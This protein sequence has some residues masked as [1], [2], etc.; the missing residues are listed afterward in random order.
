MRRRVVVVAIAL[1]LFVPCLIVSAQ[2]PCPTSITSLDDCPD[3]GCGRGGDGELNRKKNRT[4]SPDDVE[5][6]TLGQI[7]AMS[8][9][10]TWQTGQD[11][12]SIANG[13]DKAVVVR[14]YLIDARQ[15][16]PETTNCRLTGA[17]NNDWHLDLVSFRSGPRS[18]RASAVSAEVT[19]RLRKDGWT[20]AKLRRLS[21]DRTYVRVTGWLM[22]DT[23]HIRRPLV[24]STNWEIHPVTKFEVCTSSI[25]DCRNG[26]GWEDL[27]DFQIQ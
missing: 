13:E 9:P 16:G 1:C 3:T 23:M 15:S 7:R 25:T 14:A 11:R 24:R 17:A 10:D 5:V 21:R 26:N 22:L 27:E 4:S 19:P 12:S 2:Q 8:E 6:R 18:V 20:M